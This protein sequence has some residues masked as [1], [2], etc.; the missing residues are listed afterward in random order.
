MSIRVQ[1]SIKIYLQKNFTLQQK[2]FSRQFSEN[3]RVIKKLKNNS[4]KVA[5]KRIRF[6]KPPV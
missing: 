1:I 4:K 2:I 5:Q 6:Q 3:Q